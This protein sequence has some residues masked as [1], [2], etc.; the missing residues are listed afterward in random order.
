MSLLALNPQWLPIALQGPAVWPRP[1]PPTPCSYSMHLG[2]QAR[3]TELTKHAILCPLPFARCLFS[4]L[5]SF[6]TPSFMKPCSALPARQAEFNPLCS[7]SFHTLFT[8]PVLFGFPQSRLSQGFGSSSLF[9]G[10]PRRHRERAAEREKPA[11]GCSGAG[12]PGV[13][14]QQGPRRA[15]CLRRGPA[16]AGL[17]HYPS[18]DR[19]DA[20]RAPLSL[21]APR[22][23]PATQSWRR[24]S[25]QHEERL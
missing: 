20:G 1:P 17:R 6:K 15:V 7:G 11:R 2:H 16:R 4:S 10:D 21:D 23:S 13:Q 19:P 14:C 9:G 8:P 12:S 22:S 25:V 3:P 18:T 24:E 5:S